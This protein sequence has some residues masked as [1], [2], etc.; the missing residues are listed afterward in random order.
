MAMMAMTTNNSINVKAAGIN[1]PTEWRGCRFALIWDLA[2]DFKQGI[3]MGFILDSR[4]VPQN[5]KPFSLRPAFSLAA[6][7]KVLSAMG[8]NR[9]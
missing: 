8:D 3:I 1:F 2:F 6:S 7:D 9:A 4:P 5:C